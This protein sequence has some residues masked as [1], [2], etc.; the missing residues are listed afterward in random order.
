[1]TKK[2]S[3]NILIPGSSFGVYILTF[4]C[5]TSI[6]GGV[7]ASSFQASIC[8]TDQPSWERTEIGLRLGVEMLRMLIREL[9]TRCPDGLLVSK[10]VVSELEGRQRV[11]EARGDF[12]GVSIESRRSSDAST[13]AVRTRRREW[14]FSAIP[15]E[16]RMRWLEKPLSH[17]TAEFLVFFCSFSF[18]VR[19][20][21]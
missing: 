5:D 12:S 6:W 14:G 1:M 17:G 7:G 4:I 13:E 16:L 3:S 8:F 19:N 11:A 20:K 9:E 21:R 2:D 18:K 10:F 15:G